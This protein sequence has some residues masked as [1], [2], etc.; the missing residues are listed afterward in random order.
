MISAPCPVRTSLL[1]LGVLSC[2]VS[3]LAMGCSF[4]QPITTPRSAWNQILATGAIDRALKQLE[5]PAVQGRTVYV[6]VGPPR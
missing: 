3:V 5:W 2:V 1:L 6:Q 4:S